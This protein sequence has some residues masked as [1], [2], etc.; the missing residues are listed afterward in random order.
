MHNDQAVSEKHLFKVS[1]KN[2]CSKIQERRPKFQTYLWDVEQ[3]HF[4][5]YF[6]M[7]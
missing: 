6:D 5:V 4:S 2:R 7:K 1:A 3:P